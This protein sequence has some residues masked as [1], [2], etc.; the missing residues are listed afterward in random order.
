MDYSGNT[1]AAIYSL[2]LFHR[3]GKVKIL[4]GKAG[5]IEPLLSYIHPSHEAEHE[6]GHQTGH[7]GLTE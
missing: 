4:E 7:D 3:S 5:T 2:L 1:P 6:S